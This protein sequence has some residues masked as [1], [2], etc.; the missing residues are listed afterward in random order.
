MRINEQQLQKT[1]WMNITNKMLRSQEEKNV[2]RFHLSRVQKHS[3]QP[4]QIEIGMMVT[5]QG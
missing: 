3:K 1:P 5:S 2:V 4:L